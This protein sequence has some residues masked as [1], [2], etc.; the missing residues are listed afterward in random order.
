MVIQKDS[1]V[2]VLTKAHY[3]MVLQNAEASEKEVKL[4]LF[5]MPQVR[6]L[7]GAG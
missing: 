3:G 7:R 5:R 6:S 2:I 4:M 1:E